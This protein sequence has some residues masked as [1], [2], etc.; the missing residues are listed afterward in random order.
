M[1][2]YIHKVISQAAKMM[3][4]RKSIDHLSIRFGVVLLLLKCLA[5]A[6]NRLLAL[7][8]KVFAIIGTPTSRSKAS[9]KFWLATKLQTHMYR[10]HP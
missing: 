2:K 1:T 8:T 7:L 10:R 9:Q 5:Q 3:G 6:R 4:P